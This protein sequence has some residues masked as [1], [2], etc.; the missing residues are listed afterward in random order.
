MKK[1]KK[2]RKEITDIVIGWYKWD[3]LGHL[4]NI[5]DKE[6]IEIE[7]IVNTI[8]TQAHLMEIKHKGYELQK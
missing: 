7:N 6:I 4:R 8:M 1:M 2:I 5:S 3:D